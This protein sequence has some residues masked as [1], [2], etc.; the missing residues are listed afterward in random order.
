MYVLIFIQVIP[1]IQILEIFGARLIIHH[2]VMIQIQLIKIVIYN[3]YLLYY[4]FIYI[5]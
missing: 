4:L 5:L 1:T 3:Y 2:Q